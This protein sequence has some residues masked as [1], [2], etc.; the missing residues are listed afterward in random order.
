MSEREGSRSPIRQVPAPDLRP[1]IDH[2]SSGSGDGVEPGGRTPGG[3][4]RLQRL[5]AAAV[6]LVVVAGGIAFAWT[7]F[8]HGRN[9]TTAQTPP[10]S[11]QPLP[12]APA[13][14]VGAP[15]KGAA[16][17]CEATLVTPVVRPGQTPVVRFRLTNRGATTLKYGAYPWNDYAE[18]K[19]ASGA[20]VGS[21]RDHFAG[22]EPS[23]PPPVVTETLKGGRSADFSGDYEPLI[24]WDGPLSIHLACPF[25]IGHL[26]GNSMDMV[27]SPTLPPLPLRVFAPGPAPSVGVAVD[28]AVGATDGLF[29]ACR[30]R[31][32]GSAVTGEIRPPRVP[33]P[34]K[35]QPEPMQALCGA[36][37]DRHQGFDVVTLWFVTP[38]DA[39]VPSSGDWQHGGGGARVPNLPTVEVFQWTFVVTPSSTVS[40]LNRHEGNSADPTVGYD[41][42]PHGWVTGDLSCSASGYVGNGLEFPVP[43]NPCGR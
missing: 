19:D 1:R 8:G 39:P 12:S 5:L 41:H 6:A 31:A 26:N 21:W 7:A 18:V 30:P 43:T 42:G 2:A 13:V 11:P 37:I 22:G 33:K 40:A 3:S 35:V 36:G 29:D 17:F 9:Q 34:P 4:A 20:T 16:A 10:T 38:P 25:V 32:D 14:T 15:F 24:R 27:P 23:L 28:R